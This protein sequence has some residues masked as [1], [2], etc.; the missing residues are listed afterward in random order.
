MLYE[1]PDND[2][3]C[4]GRLHSGQSGAGAARFTKQDIDLADYLG[5]DDPEGENTGSKQQT[6]RAGQ[7]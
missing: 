1:M 2:A 3:G 7:M 6:A 4:D 5:I